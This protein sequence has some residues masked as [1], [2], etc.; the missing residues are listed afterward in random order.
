MSRTYRMHEIHFCS[1]CHRPRKHTP[2][3]KEHPDKCNCAPRANGWFGGISSYR[4]IVK[5]SDHKPWYKP[6][7]SFKQMSRRRFRA[8]SKAALHD[9][10]YKGKDFIPPVNKK[11]DVWN[12]T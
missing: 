7:K 1:N 9:H 5:V 4:K 11:T 2:H 3:V 12:W 8:K 10:V 6:P